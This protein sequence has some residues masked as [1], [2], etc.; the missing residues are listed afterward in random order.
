LVLKGALVEVI[1]TFLVD[2][3]P[4]VIAGCD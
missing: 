3:V 4:D 1:L 2:P